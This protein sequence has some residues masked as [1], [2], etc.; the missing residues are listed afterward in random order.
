M[1]LDLYTDLT[2]NFTT[3]S[4]YFC[5]IVFILYDYID[6]IIYTSISTNERR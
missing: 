6:K 4:E 5:F 1:F 3:I 2:Q